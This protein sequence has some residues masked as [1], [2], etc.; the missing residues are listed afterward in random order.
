M[1]TKKMQALF[2]LKWDPFSQDIPAEAIFRTPRFDQFCYRVETL[3]MDGGFALITGE[4]GMGKSANLRALYDHLSKIPEIKVGD[5]IRPQSGLADFYREMGTLFG[6]ELRNSNRWGGYRGL[7]EQWKHHIATTLLR[8]VLL[9]DEAQEIPHAVLSEMRL[10]SMDKFDS[11][12]LL[13]IVLAGDQRLTNAF[14]SENLIPLGTRMKTRL[15]MEPWMKPQLIELLN[16]STRLAGNQK[17]LSPGLT[18]TLAEHAAGSPRVLM[19][20]AAE[21]LVT[22]MYKEKTQLDEGLFFELF[23]APTTGSGSR[24]KPALTSAK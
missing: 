4:S 11:C 21:C 15:V 20:L 10:L 16:E 14:K 8:P 13:T 7:R 24:R 6:V 23:P 12:C 1:S 2:G 17:L 9:I 22:G 3:T 5:I 19:N 18:E